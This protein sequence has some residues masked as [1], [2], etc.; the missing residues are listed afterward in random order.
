MS[1]RFKEYFLLKEDPDSANFRIGE[2]NYYERFGGTGNPI[3]FAVIGQDFLVY[4][5][6]HDNY[7]N[8]I[9]LQLVNRIFNPKLYYTALDIPVPDNSEIDNSLEKIK[10]DLEE[11]N[12]IYFVGDFNK[13]I[14]ERIEFIYNVDVNA[15]PSPRFFLR[16]YSSR[17]FILGRMWSLSVEEFFS[18]KTDEKI[19]AFSLWNSFKHLT[20]KIAETMLKLPLLFHLDPNKSIIEDPGLPSKMLKSF[21]K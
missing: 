19:P 18:E 15:F 14:V 9:S 11:N 16:P 2:K 17:D 8:D 12:K 20:P 4:S 10:S 1:L 13:E 21:I 5:R 6:T 3:T 7:H